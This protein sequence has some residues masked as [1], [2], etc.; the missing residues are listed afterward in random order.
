LN[1]TIQL[2][3]SRLLLDTL[4]SSAHRPRRCRTS[5]HNIED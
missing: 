5:W 1:Y 3:F 4:P 2:V